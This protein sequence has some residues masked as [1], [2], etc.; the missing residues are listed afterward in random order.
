MHV[1]V[2]RAE[3]ETGPL[4]S[5]LRARGLVPVACPLLVEVGLDDE[6]PLRE[7]A[8]RLASYDWLVV[9]STRSVDALRT[10]MD[11]RP[12]PHGLRSA[13]VGP[14]TAAALSAVGATPRP[15]VAGTAGAAALWDT[16]STLDTWAGRRVLVLTTPGGRPTLIDALRAADAHVDA[17]DAYRMEAR[18]A[19]RIRDDWSRA[20]PDAAVLASP[21]S[22]AALVAAIGRDGVARL[23]AVVAIGQT[24]AARLAELGVPCLVSPDASFEAAAEVLA[25]LGTAT[26]DRQ[27]APRVDTP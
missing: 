13:A 3:D 8:A 6:T 27:P 24:T 2:T 17:V 19:E 22:A 14:A 5:A 12:W 4:G 10:T 20:A 26:P 16:L 9:A 11:R 15:I 25:S 21:R 1:A 23:H 7:A 18:P